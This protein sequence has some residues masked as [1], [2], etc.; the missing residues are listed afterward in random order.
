M[1]PWLPGM[2][3][4][5]AGLIRA[6]HSVNTTTTR[7]GRELIISMVVH[8][9]RDCHS[10]MAWLCIITYVGDSTVSVASA[11]RTVSGSV[12]LGSLPNPASLASMN[13]FSLVS[14]HQPRVATT[15]VTSATPTKLSLQLPLASLT[16]STT[17]AEQTVAVSV[18]PHSPPIP[19]KPADKIWRNE[20]VELHE[21]LPSRLGIPA[22][23]LLDVLA[24]PSTPK[25][26]LKQIS[27]IE[28]WV[29]CLNTYTALI[30]LKQPDRIKDLLAYSSI[31][32][33]A[34]KQFEGTLWLEYD[35]RFR[36]EAAVQP[37]KQ[38]ATIDAST[39]T[40]CFTSAKPKSE[41][42]RRGQE[43][44]FHPYKPA[45]KT[46]C[47][48]FNNHRCFWKECH[49]RHVCLLCEKPNHTD[50]QCPERRLAKGGP[51]QAQQK[52]F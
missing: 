16:D 5:R 4:W 22:P 6:N 25:T 46:I 14:T 45:S 32:V 13:T 42:M 10:Y 11:S 33:N 47:R 48:N 44:R 20:F 51:F 3:T 49:Y 38:W 39:W 40:L 31:I 17:K 24:S 34:S 35:T 36:N 23:T 37:G 52:P 2:H 27:T 15:M 9:Q 12:V 26:P 50:D 29:M 7:H 41:P 1:Q 19:K 21:L 30:A 43:K 28:E 18:G 8:A